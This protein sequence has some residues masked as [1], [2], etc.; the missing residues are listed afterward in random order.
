[1][2][3]PIKMNLKHL[4]QRLSVNNSLRF[5]H[6]NKNNFGCYHNAV[7]LE[8]DFHI[9][10]VEAW[11]V[12]E[13]LDEAYFK[14]LMELIERFVFSSYCCLEFKNKKFLRSEKK[15]F[16]SILS[17]FPDLTPS[18][19]CPNNS[20]G[21]ALGSSIGSAEKRAFQ[22]LLERH[23]ILSSMVLSVSPLKVSNIKRYYH[24]QNTILFSCF[25]CVK[26]PLF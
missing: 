22:E 6:Y 5:Y 11:G 9:G 25:A 26:I 4:I 18:L 23:V 21:V 8:A 7:K 15:F 16:S 20:N 24:P 14:A 12:A 10:L 2:E 19:L 13:N 3:D 1:M 17:S